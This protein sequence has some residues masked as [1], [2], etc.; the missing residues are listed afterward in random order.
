MGHCRFLYAFSFLV[1]E[2]KCDHGLCQEGMS[3]RLGLAAVWVDGDGR[4]RVGLH[5]KVKLLRVFSAAAKGRRGEQV[6]G[7][8]HLRCV[9]SS[10]HPSTP[11]PKPRAAGGSRCWPRPARIPECWWVCVPEYRVS[12]HRP[13]PFMLPWMT[14]SQHLAGQP[15]TKGT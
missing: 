4:A 12:A 7:W 6:S 2:G 5:W 10:A 15:V 9:H 1:G 8:R 13:G 14:G 11:S 3:A